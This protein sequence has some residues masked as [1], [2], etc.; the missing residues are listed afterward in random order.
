MSDL[1]EFPEQVYVEAGDVFE[2]F[3][4]ELSRFTLENAR[5]MMWFAQLAYE[6][7]DTGGNK[8]AAKI[9]KVAD[10]WNFSAIARS[11]SAPHRSENPSIPL[12]SSGSGAT[13]SYWHSPAQIRAYGKPW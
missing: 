8:N 13:Q 4:G 6:V 3:K 2:Q 11:G 7:D 10:R 9:A 12:A 5:A 1:V